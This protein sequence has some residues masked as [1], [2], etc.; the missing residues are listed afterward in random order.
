MR[1]SWQKAQGTR[2][3]LSER[4]LGMITRGRRG[5]CSLVVTV[6]GLGEQ[7]AKTYTVIRTC[8]RLSVAPWN[9]LAWVLPKLTDPPINRG[10][11][12][13]NTLTPWTYKERLSA[14]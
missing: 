14:I 11:G 12:H 5:T 13:L 2:N 8:Q 10:K 7:L 3:N 6:Q 4:E 9:Y 1:L